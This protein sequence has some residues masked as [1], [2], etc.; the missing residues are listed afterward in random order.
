MSIGCEL[1]V[2]FGVASVIVGIKV[3]MRME[4]TRSSWYVSLVQHNHVS[5]TN[6]S[7]RRH[8]EGVPVYIH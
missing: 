5:S 2:I 8:L 3:Q 4:T 6:L 1:Q 7:M